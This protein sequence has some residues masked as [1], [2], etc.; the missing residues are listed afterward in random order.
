MSETLSA[1]D[2]NIL[3]AEARLSYSEEVRARLFTMRS[4]LRLYLL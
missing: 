3:S 2:T 1:E 4:A